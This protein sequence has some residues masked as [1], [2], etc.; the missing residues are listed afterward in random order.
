ML[1]DAL[2]LL[3]CPHCGTDWDPEAS[4]PRT[5]VCAEGHRYDAARQG[6]VSFLTGRGTGF[7]PDTAE[8]VAAR[9]RFLTAGHYAP[10]AEALAEACGPLREDA[11]LLDAGAGTGYYLAAVLGLRGTAA[12]GT[13]AVGAAAV[14]SADARR[15]RAVALDLSPH[16]LRRAARLPG[17]AAIV[18]DLWRPLP[19]AAASVDGV[20]DVFS[21]RNLPEFARVTRR[22]GLLCVVTPLP[23]HLAELR[24][25]LPLLSVPE[26]KAE[27]LEHAASN[28]YEPVSRVP[29]EFP[30]AL[31]PGAAAD[32]V[33]MGPAGHHTDRGE[34][35]R[36]VG[37]ETLNA[38]AAVELSVLRRR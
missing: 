3:I 1:T 6:Y 25:R 23:G 8:M 30:L 36:L 31:S 12:V 15:R 10:I 22:G 28:D 37:G 16:A 29:L 26:G 18:W 20:L 17:V 14:G 33:Q 21:P 24:E 38:T 19:L 34:L 7:T 4:G 27:A 13:A 11:A 5:L 32:L 2:D 9:D 35:E